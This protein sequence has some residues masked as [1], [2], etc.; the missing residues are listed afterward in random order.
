LFKQRRCSFESRS[1]DEGAAGL[2][3]SQEN[4]EDVTE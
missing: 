2:L 1:Q 4:E 3:L